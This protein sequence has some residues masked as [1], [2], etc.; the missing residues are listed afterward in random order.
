MNPV[1][2]G[3]TLLHK[4][5]IDRF[6]RRTD[7][8]LVYE[9][10]DTSR[11]RRVTIM[12]LERAASLDAVKSAHFHD[13]ARGANVIDIGT[14]D[15][16]AYFVTAERVLAPPPPRKRPSSK[17]PPLPKPKPPPL[18]DIPI[19]VDDE[20]IIA[21]TPA[22]PPPIPSDRVMTAFE[23]PPPER[24]RA[25]W[26]LLVAGAM[27]ITGLGGWYIGR[28]ESDITPAAAPDPI[29]TQPTTTSEPERAAP[30]L[31]IEPVVDASPP[32]ASAPPPVPSSKPRPR[33]TADP[34][35]L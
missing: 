4:Y 18:P 10:I 2:L 22:P 3:S 6:R 7:G 31:V 11:C 16:L 9:G 35:T 26:A 19:F 12:L 17:P 34:L 8:V 15:G 28:G 29:S 25:S 20:A 32:V 23:S 21:S 33:P 27:I 5:R 24:K 13:E 1:Q 30:P 14:C